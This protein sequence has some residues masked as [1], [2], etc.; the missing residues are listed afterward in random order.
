M[1]DRLLLLFACLLD[2]L[3]FAW[4]VWEEKEWLFVCLY[5]GFHI[6]VI[7]RYLP[8]VYMNGTCWSDSLLAFT[9]LGYE[10]QD[11]LSPCVGIYAH[12]TTDLP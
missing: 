5:M 9:V 1:C 10:C 2:F 8:S 6:P 11:L 3:C 7:E 12:D 4:F